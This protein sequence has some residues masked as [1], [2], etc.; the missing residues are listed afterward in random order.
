MTNRNKNANLS[1]FIFQ[2]A[3]SQDEEITIS[4][5][6]ALDAVEFIKNQLD[7]LS[8]VGRER[9][10]ATNAEKSK[11]YRERKKKLKS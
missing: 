7:R 3:M 5:D 9:K 11:A 1:A 6:I 10:Y 2:V 8:K 4:R